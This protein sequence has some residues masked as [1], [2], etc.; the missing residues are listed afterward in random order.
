M[1]RCKVLK[2]KSMAGIYGIEKEYDAYRDSEL[3]PYTKN[4]PL[5]EVVS[6]VIPDK[7]GTV[8]S[9][10]EFLSPMF[11]VKSY[12]SSTIGTKSLAQNALDYL[13]NKKHEYNMDIISVS[14]GIEDDKLCA[15]FIVRIYTP[16]KK[17]IKFN[18][19]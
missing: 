3:I 15:M 6:V 13:N 11:L 14:A 10:E 2:I 12:H 5:S 17:D 4:T 9:D 16:E 7:K 8:G 19:L 1:A 18:N